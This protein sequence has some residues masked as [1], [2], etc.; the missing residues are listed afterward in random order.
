MKIIYISMF[1]WRYVFSRNKE[2]SIT[3]V[4][5]IVLCESMY[6][7]IPD[8]VININSHEAFDKSNYS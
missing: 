7:G 8:H 6:N 4:E 2:I 5:D 1:Y 3:Y